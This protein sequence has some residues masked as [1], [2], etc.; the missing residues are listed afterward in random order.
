MNIRLRCAVLALAVA[1]SSCTFSNLSFREDRRITIVSPRDRED[2]RP[3]FQL[4]WTARD[5]ETGPGALGSND[6]YFMI[7]VDRQPM[8]PG[9]TVKSLGD[10]I[11][12]RRS[13]CPNEQ[14]L[15]ERWIFATASTSLEFPALPA[16]LP[17]TTR[18]GTKEDHTITIVLMDGDR[19]IGE[20]AFTVE[21]F[22]TIRR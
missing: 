22:R 15:G 4:R 13:D 11:C 5:F 21:F 20:S 7:F 1:G 9:G 10:D 17:E 16:L 3:P 6:K 12:R 8:R 18:G 2:V 19:R 14:W